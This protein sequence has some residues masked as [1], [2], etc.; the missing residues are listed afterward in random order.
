MI[1]IAAASKLFHEHKIQFV[2]F[3]AP[4]EIPATN[5]HIFLRHTDQSLSG[6]IK[7]PNPGENEL[8]FETAGEAINFCLALTGHER[9]QSFTVDFTVNGQ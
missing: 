3:C 7:S 6:F 1:T 5:W 4:L 9:Y 2:R 8:Q